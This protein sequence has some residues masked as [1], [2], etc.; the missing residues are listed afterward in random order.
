MQLPKAVTV[1]TLIKLQ[2]CYTMKDNSQNASA[3]YQHENTDSLIKIIL[4]QNRLPINN[5]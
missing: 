1:H 3:N 2:I 5:P 4:L